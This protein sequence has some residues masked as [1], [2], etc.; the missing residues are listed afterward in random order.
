MSKFLKITGLAAAAIVPF[1]IVDRRRSYKRIEEYRAITF[2]SEFGKMAYVDEGQGEAILISHG[3]FGGYDQGMVSLRGT[4]GEEYRKISLSRFGYPGSELPTEPTP[5]NQAK[6][7]TELLDRLKVDKVFVL[8]TSAGGAAAISFALGFPDR[9]KGLILVSSIVPFHKITE[10][11]AKRAGPP[12]AL[13]S[14][15]TIWL[16]TKFMHPV[17]VKIFGSKVDKAFFQT[18]LPIKPRREGIETDAELTNLDMDVHYENY[19]VEEIKAPVL[20]IHAKDDPMTQ[21]TSTKKFIARTH[22]ETVTFE[23]GG[24]LMSGHQKEGATAIKQFISKHA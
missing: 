23:S 10:E 17:F 3:I 18:M 4:L 19:P 21:Y 20:V 11:Q 24:H 13:L 7:F 14:D 2:T 22:P 12:R 1:Y 16:S 9:I 5:Q 15:F 6:V 8:A